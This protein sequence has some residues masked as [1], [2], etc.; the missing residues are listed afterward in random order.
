MKNTC[1]FQVLLSLFMLLISATALAHPGHDHADWFSDGIHLLH[2]GTVAL[3]VVAIVLIGIL[4]TKRT[5]KKTTQ[6]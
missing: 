6:K 2:Y 4:K 3:I 5:S 1:Q